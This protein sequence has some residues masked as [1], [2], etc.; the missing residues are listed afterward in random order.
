MTTAD[1][2]PVQQAI[3]EK[4]VNHPFLS[5]VIMVIIAAIATYFIPAGEFE[6]VMIDGRAVIDPDS[7][8]L[9]ESNPTTLSSFF[10]SFF[11]GFTSASGVMGVVAFVG[12]AFGVIKRMGI[13][14]TSV[15]ALTT[16]LNKQGLY[17]IAPVIMIAIFFNVTFTGM[18]ELDVIFI[19]LM[20][21]ICIKLGYDAMTALGVVLLSSCAGFAAALANPFFT[22]IA[23]SIAELPMYS[24]MWYR[25][26][27]G[28]F[29][30]L[31]GIAYVL[32]YARK[33]KADPTR[34]LLYGTGYSYDAK[35]EAK[36][37]TTREKAAGITF[38]AIFGY[39]IFGTL[40]MSFGFTE[41]AGCFVAMAIIPGL[42]GG[43]SPNRIC[44]Y[45]TKGV[46]DV[47]VA[48]LIIFFARSVLTIMEDAMIVDSV[49]YYLAQIIS[50][51]SQL[52]AAAGIY[53]SQA[54]INLFIPSGSGQAVITMPIIIPLADI[55]D[56]TRQVAVLA[57][58]LGDGIS[59]YI[60]PTN[61][62]LL[63]VLAIAQVPYGKWVKFFLPLFIFWSATALIAVVI[64]QAIELGPF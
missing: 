39:M 48:V 32:T 30:L 20:I 54:L 52:A 10:E 64:A 34:S 1:T 37:L 49:I 60:Y 62:G 15:V 28:M 4:E 63:A 31:T 35:I 9:I 53:F 51:S 44:D 2:R 27:V 42:V 12:G 38:L 16:K 21:P 58:Q 18:R 13:L 57:S 5:L 40:K 55:G 61:G 22:G 43:L 23:H 19:A 3:P 17:V 6:R 56:V 26:L 11:K 50:G 45:W 33:V 7:Y 59:N 46:S 8:T 41:I 29:M 14:D 47:M 36:V 24:G 25:F